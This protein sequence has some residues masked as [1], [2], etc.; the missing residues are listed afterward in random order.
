MFRGSMVA[1]VTPFRKGKVDKKALEH[2]VEF[3]IQNGTKA[4]V[5]CGTTGESPTLNHEEHRLVIEITVKAAAGRIPVI[6]GT[7]SNSTIEALELTRDAKKIGADGALVV[8]PYYNRPTQ[9]GL[10]QHFAS[11][12][13]TVR[14]PIVIYN[15]PGRT[16]VNILP[17]TFQRLAQFENIVGVKEASGSLDQ[18]SQIMAVAPSIAMISGDDSLT[19]PIL[20]IGGVGV[21][22]VLANIVPKEI[23][24]MIDA[25]DTGDIE[26][27][28]NIHF[29][30]FSLCKVLFSETNPT[31]IKAAMALMGL[32]SDEIRL[33]LV[34]MSEGNRK[35]LEKELKKLKLI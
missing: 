24:D 13:E 35:A 16:G 2:L 22:S 4:L 30:L 17:E 25:W 10:F 8:A 21:I 20:A 26:E 11:I 18:M 15:I 31:P 23:Q 28:R 29:K 14:F 1:L 12:A 32:I 7:G 9:E 34:K 6:A 33:P 5:P 3:H 19:L 27:A